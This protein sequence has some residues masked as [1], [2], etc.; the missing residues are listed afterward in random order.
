M[1]IKPLRD[2]LYIIP[3]DYD[4]RSRSSIIYT[5]PKSIQRTNQGIVKYRGPLT[6]GEIRRGDHVFFSGYDGD[7]IVMEEEGRLII[8]P[9]EFIDAIWVDGE[10][11]WVLSKENV[12]KLMEE[13][14]SVTAQEFGRNYRD[15]EG[16][17]QI[18]REVGA[19]MRE[20]LDDSQ[21]MKELWF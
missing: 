3:I 2:L 14:A 5:T 18:A 17:Q 6:T 15:A 8:I 7:E 9:E 21:F 13:A 20:L 16:R 1:P 4:E 10:T 19:R 12:G 11:T